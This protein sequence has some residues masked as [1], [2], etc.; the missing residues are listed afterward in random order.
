M[1]FLK[2]LKSDDTIQNESDNLGGGGLLESNT[3]LL[4]IKLAYITTAD[5]GAVA[6]NIRANT[7]DGKRN[8]STALDDFRHCQRL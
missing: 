8:S 4:E 2:N 6:L 3:Y 5:S 1:S 7:E